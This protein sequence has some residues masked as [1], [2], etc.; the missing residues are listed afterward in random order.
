MVPAEGSVSRG[1]GRPRDPTYDDAIREATTELLAR[2]G[3]RGLTMSGVARR[4]GVAKTTIYRRWDTK[5]ELVLDTV[6]EGLQLPAQREAD[7]VGNP[8]EALRRLVVRFYA[9]LAGQTE[10]Q[11]P[12]APARLL[13]EADV[14]DAFRPRFLQPVRRHGTALIRRARRCGQ[15]DDDTAAVELMDMLLAPAMYLAMAVDE[16]PRSELAERVF[17]RLVDR[18]R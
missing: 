17:D 4:A 6:A 12:V 5:A 16:L 10:Q 1:R 11:L 18:G 9:V 2:Q 8:L 3:Y 13:R 7:R 15:L 14:V